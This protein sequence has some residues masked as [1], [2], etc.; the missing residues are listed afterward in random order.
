MALRR[1]YRLAA[2]VTV[3]FGVHCTLDP[4]NPQ[5]LP[6]KEEARPSDSGE[7]GAGDATSADPPGAS[8]DAAGS[9]DTSPV[10]A[11]SPANTPGT[12]AGDA[13]TDAGDASTDSASP[14]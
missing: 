7:F 12:D 5:P 8:R 11:G 4:L 13:S 1:A 14:P 6:P 9:V 10:E 2:L 3:A